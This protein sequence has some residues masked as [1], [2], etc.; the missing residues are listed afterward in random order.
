MHILHPKHVKLDE[1]EVKDLLGDLN[2]SKSQLPKILS[3]DPGLPENCNVG[4]I[5][6]IERKSQKDGKE[7]HIYY[8]VV[9]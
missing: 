7:Q 9:V 4:D 5:V 6:R 1:K 8:R 2:I 3:S